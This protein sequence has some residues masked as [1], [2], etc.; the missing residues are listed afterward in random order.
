MIALPPTDEIELDPGLEK[1]FG[2]TANNSVCLLQIGLPRNFVHLSHIP[3][4]AAA[5]ALASDF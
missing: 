4:A 1:K 5:I 3:P 2:L